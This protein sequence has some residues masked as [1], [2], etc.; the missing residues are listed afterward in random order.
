MKCNNKLIKT[1]ANIDGQF[2]LIYLD[3]LMKL[4]KLL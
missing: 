4:S 3:D 1:T 2:Y